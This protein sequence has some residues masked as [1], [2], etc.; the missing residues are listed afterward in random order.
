MMRTKPGVGSHKEHNFFAALAILMAVVVA[1]GFS[2][3]FF[4]RPWFPEAQHLAAPETFFLVHGVVFSAWMLL[5][6]AQ[7]LL[8]RSGRTQAHQQLGML[9]MG[10]ATAVVIYG[11]W[12]ALIAASRRGG[13]IG[14]SMPPTVFLAIPIFDMLLFGGLVGLAYRKR[15]DPQSH[16]RLM[17]IATINLLEAAF[18]R[19]TPSWVVDVIGPLANFWL[20]DLFLLAL[21]FWDLGWARRLH[22]VT[23]WAGLVTV[24]SQP[25][26][27]AVGGTDIWGT[28]AS[29]AIGSSG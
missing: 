3:T 1:I 15:R 7:A 20:S 24:A 12:G 9:G 29:W 8:I 14:V 19:L 25:L 2:R 26:R 17:V 18:V 21:V 5:F 10:I 11:C 27:F 4:L 16:K 28:I 6:V 13:F 22:P 23:L